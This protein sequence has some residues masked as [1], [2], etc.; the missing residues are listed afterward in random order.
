MKILIISRNT[1]PMQSPRAF[2]TQ[3]LSE[4][5]VKMGHSVILYT[6]Q[7]K[8]DYSSYMK[9][10]GIQL[11]PIIMKHSVSANDNT[12]RMSK[13]DRLFAKLFKKWFYYPDIEF[14]FRMKDILKAEANVD[15]L[16]TIAQPH[17]IHWGVK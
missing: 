12:G 8:Y 2:R 4:Q 1:F 15:L 9:E 14:V 13:V 10:T 3:E 16:I 6:V 7:G 5:L 11:K 17:S